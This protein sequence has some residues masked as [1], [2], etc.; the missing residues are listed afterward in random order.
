MLIATADALRHA[1]PRNLEGL[2]LAQLWFYKHVQGGSDTDLHAERGAV[3]VYL[4]VPRIKLRSILKV[5]PRRDLA[6]A[7]T[8][9]LDFN[10]GNVE[11]GA[12]RPLPVGK[13]DPIT[14]PHRCNRLV[15][16]EAN[17]FHRTSPGRFKSGYEDRR[18]NITF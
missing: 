14:V 1:L 6:G 13:G 4:W 5:A 7:N 9:G 16:F 15:L 3:S 12:I 11:R 2:G 8:R 10:H 18:A 17:L